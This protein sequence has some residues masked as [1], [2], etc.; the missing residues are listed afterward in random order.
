MHPFNGILID[1]IRKRKKIALPPTVGVL[2]DFV[3]HPTWEDSADADAITVANRFAVPLVEKKGFDLSI[4]HETGI[5]V[6]ARFAAA[7]DRREARRELGLDE[8]TDTVLVMGGSMGRGRFAAN[9]AAID[10]LGRDLQIICVS[11]HN[12][13]AK[14]SVD[15]VAASPRHRILSLGFVG[16]VDRIMDAADVIVSKPGG[17]STSEAFAKRLPLIV[18]DPIPGHEVKNAELLA[19]RGAVLLTDREHDAASRVREFFEDEALRRSLADAVG[20]VRRP[21]AAR[22]VCELVISLMKNE[23]SPEKETVQ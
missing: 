9:V 19:E 8:D 20:D 16:N 12:K 14:R 11:G 6:E 13:R 22:D 1:V 17:L 15:R 23:K 2:T 7:G 18:V 3:I 4:F 5:P 10:A 21:D